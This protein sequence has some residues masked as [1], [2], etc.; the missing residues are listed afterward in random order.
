[1][2][3]L[4]G[5]HAVKWL[6]LS[7]K[8]HLAHL[9]EL[10]VHHSSPRMCFSLTI[11]CAI[12][13]SSQS[14][15]ALQNFSLFLFVLHI[16]DNLSFTEVF[17]TIFSVSYAGTA[18]ISSSLKGGKT[19]PEARFRLQSTSPVCSVWHNKRWHVYFML[20]IFSCSQ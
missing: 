13:A 17:T 12:T 20:A 15:D 5:S 3:I 8:L 11:D 2:E 4:D 19:D 10:L 1:V 7:R 9:W 6:A 16:C 14:S 18:T